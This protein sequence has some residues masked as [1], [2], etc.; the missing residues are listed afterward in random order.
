MFIIGDLWAFGLYLGGALIV[1]ANHFDGDHTVMLG[2]LGLEYITECT[3]MKRREKR[4]VRDRELV[5]I[6]VQTNDGG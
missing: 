4:E 5:S 1:L 6:H 3:T 2:V